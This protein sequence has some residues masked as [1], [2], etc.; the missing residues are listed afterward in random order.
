MNSAEQRSI[1]EF[2]E[3]AKEL[4]SLMYAMTEAELEKVRVPDLSN[5]STRKHKAL[6]VAALTVDKAIM[7]FIATFELELMKVARI[8]CR[9]A[10][11]FYRQGCA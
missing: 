8:P 6:I 10:G 9:K 1:R 7:A 5:P 11:H 3:K 2:E 4:V